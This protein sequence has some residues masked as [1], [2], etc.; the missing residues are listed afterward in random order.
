MD[1]GDATLKFSWD[2]TGRQWR[3][4]VH[5]ARLGSQIRYR[6]QTHDAQRCV[7]ATAGVSAQRRT[8]SSSGRQILLGALHQLDFNGGVAASSSTLLKGPGPLAL[9]LPRTRAFRARVART[10]LFNAMDDKLLSEPM[11]PH[12]KDSR[13]FLAKREND[14]G[15]LY[16]NVYQNSE[17][18]RV[19][20]LVHGKIREHRI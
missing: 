4:A 6:A 14:S 20:Q 15:E 9:A 10:H 13:C 8:T 3:F 1:C 7:M 19:K 12:R 18:G 5:C 16:S 11:H 2:L 17:P